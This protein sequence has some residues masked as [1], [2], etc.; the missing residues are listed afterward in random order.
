LIGLLVLCA[1]A[2][3]QQP[4]AS[5]ASFVFA[6]VE[7]GRAVLGRD[8]DWVGA[9]GDFQ[10][11][12][13][14][15]VAAPVSRQR[16]VAFLADCVRPWTAQQQARWRR[17]LDTLLPRL[18][19]LRAPLPTR[20]LFVNTNGHDAGDAPYTRGNAVMLPT[21]ALAPGS[22]GRSDEEMLAHELFHVISRNQPEL[23]TR[24]YALLGFERV[25]ALQWPQAWLPLRIANPDAPYDRDA[26]QVIVEGHSAMIMPVLVARGTELQPGA[27]LFEAMDVRLLEV[28]P[29]AAGATLPV[30]VD[31]RPVWHEPAQVPDFIDRLG[32]NTDYIIHPEETLADNFAFLVSGRAVPNPALLDRIRT[33]F[34]GPH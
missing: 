30:F 3:A 2:L 9:T 34:L 24:L 27:S 26:M 14:L 15:G 17:A 21:A 28:R 5:S 11:A 16:F 31:A 13:T 33:V 4:D 18:A 23:A 22:T 12:A 6:T 20:V 32:G 10:R 29:S 25:G 8:D 19:A 1:G 7:Q